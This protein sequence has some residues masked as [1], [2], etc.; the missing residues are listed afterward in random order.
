MS[1]P[2][3]KDLMNQEG[4]VDAAIQNANAMV[5]N[6]AGS[7]MALNSSNVST[8]EV[9]LTEEDKALAKEAAEGQKARRTAWN[10]EHK[11]S[12]FVLANYPLSKRVVAG[13]TTGKIKNAE[14]VLESTLK[15]VWEAENRPADMD[16][17]GKVD[18]VVQIPKCVQNCGQSEQYTLFITTLCEAKNGGNKEIKVN[19][20]TKPSNFKGVIV[21]AANGESSWTMAEAKKEINANGMSKLQ[22]EGIASGVQLQIKVM[23]RDNISKKKAK[24]GDGKISLED[25]TQLQIP[26]R[27]SIIDMKT[28]DILD[29]T[30]VKVYNELN[31]DVSK[32]AEDDKVP[33][34]SDISFKY[35]KAVKAS[36]GESTTKKMTRRIPLTVKTY[37]VDAS[38]VPAMQPF[39]PRQGVGVPINPLSPEEEQKSLETMYQMSFTFA[40]ETNDADLNAKRAESKNQ[41]SQAEA[42]AAAQNIAGDQ[43]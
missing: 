24:M 36:D 29:P 39:A 37:K 9:V 34:Y 42:E 25:I 38:T 22:V 13:V 2:T 19:L 20:N 23:S 6:V 32:A 28:G 21:K 11:I 4:S 35:L 16:S 15:A 41:R 14:K 33:A 30:H 12:C 5:G 10:N 26:G 8:G 17:E 3:I 40:I 7:T 31:M 18:G 1:S 27:D 43:M